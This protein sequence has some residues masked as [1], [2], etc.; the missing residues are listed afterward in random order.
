MQNTGGQKANK[1]YISKVTLVASIG[2]FLFGYD[3]SVI[4]GALPLLILDFH[5][6]PVLQGLVVGGAALGA[7]IGPIIGLWFSERLGRR[8]TMFIAAICFIASAVGS[9]FAITIWDL[10]F[11]RFVT[12]AGVG[13]AMMTSPIYIAELS[14]KET[15]GALVNVNQLTNVIGINLAIVAGYLFSF[16]GWGWRWIFGSEIIPAILLAV[17][18]FFVPE[19]PRWLAGQQRIKEALKILTVINGRNKAEDELKQIQVDLGKRKGSFAELWQSGVKAIL[20]IAILVMIFSHTNGVNIMLSYGPTILASVGFSTGTEAILASMPLYF[21]ILLCTVISFWL[22]KRFSRRGL[23]ISSVFFMAVGHVIMAVNLQQ[24]WP[25]IYTLIPMLIGVGA[26]TLGFAP[27][28]WI[29]VSEILPNRARGQAMAVVCSFS[30]LS[31]FVTAQVFP[32]LTHWFNTELGNAGGV[33]W[34]FCGICILCMVFSWRWVPE[35]KDMSLEEIGNFLQR[36]EI[37]GAKR[38]STVQKEID[39]KHL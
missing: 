31:S 6:S 25:P 37:P 32:I 24:Q 15:R 17:G 9:A 12:G 33:Y 7:V 8:K 35:T 21:F 18:L 27:L 38:L 23:L 4:S 36:K 34:I 1:F 16:E 13:L 14:P 30:F 26:F 28:S 22:I 29:I 39:S 10:I 20:I 3:I 2:G 11:W 19:S 5:L